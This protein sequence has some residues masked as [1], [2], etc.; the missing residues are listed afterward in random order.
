M[1]LKDKKGMNV[2]YLL[3]K[4]KRLDWIRELVIPA[5]FDLSQTDDAQ[6]EWLA[7]IL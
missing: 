3:R 7:K 2:V 5:G 6:R 1:N 4:R